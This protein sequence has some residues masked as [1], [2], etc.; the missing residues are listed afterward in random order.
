MKLT[1]GEM[2]Y[3]FRIKQGVEA[4]QICYGL[5]TK[6]M[7]SNFENGKNIPDILTFLCMTERM[8]IS[9]EEFSIMV[10]EKE[11]IYYQWREEVC[12]AIE[13]TNWSKLEKLLNAK[14]TKKVF[15][16][17]S[18]EKQFYL[19]ASAVY[20][21]SE[22]TY[23]KSF[24]LLNIA[25]EQTILNFSVIINKKVRLGLQ[26][27]HILML[28]LYYG[29]KE[30]SVLS[31]EKGWELFQMLEQYILGEFL[32]KNEQAI[33]YPKLVCI[34]IHSLKDRITEIKQMKLCENALELLRSEKRFCNITEILRLYIP[35]LEKYG[36]EEVK[37]Y[38]KQY[39]VFCDLLESEQI[40]TDF[41]PELFTE[42]KPKVYMIQEYLLMKRKENKLTQ[43]QVS[44]GIFEPESYSRVET[45]KRRP[46]RKN[47]IALADRLGIPWCYYRGELDTCEKEAYRLRSI[48]RN[49]DIEGKR[50][51][52]LKILSQM[53]LCLDR[54]LVCNRQYVKCHEYISKNRLSL[55]SAEETYIKLEELLSLTQGMDR[56]E[57]KIVYYSQTELEI[58][59]AMA[60]MLRK[61]EKYEK[62]ILL[63]E[64]VIK[65]M[66]NSKIDLEWQWNGVS[67]LLRILSGLYFC[68]QNYEK[69]LQ[70]ATYVKKVMLKRRSASNLSEILDAIADDLEHMGEQY[71]MEY[72]KLYRY[73]FYIADFFEIGDVVGF[74]K[75]YYEEN[76]EAEMIWY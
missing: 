47:F 11:Y 42:N 59:G 18:L 35:L 49:A 12:K 55:L 23:A 8:G 74:S 63:I 44:E 65:Q 2:L 7:M 64:T 70:G 57:T 15:C 30:Q 53:E 38:K 28:Y 36:R 62:G 29:R 54:N 19:Y 33:C 69:S 75:K 13:D 5:C 45:G 9:S 34:G 27:L 40:C 72:M 50:E 4:Q 1:L 52:S 26:E 6:A 60:Q 14:E 3:R 21:A 48:Q 41:H 71:S 51:E 46:S 20:Y 17:K 24:Q 25:I 56:D 37:F 58:I 43:I 10:S 67:F 68:I 66:K 32:D 16:N 22:N 73:T 31:T 39:E 61:Q 76:F